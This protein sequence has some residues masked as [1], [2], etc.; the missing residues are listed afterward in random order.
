MAVPDN[1]VEKSIV[2]RSAKSVVRTAL[3]GLGQIILQQRWVAGIFF[4]A[5]ISW[6]S[7]LM[8][9]AA[10][11]GSLIGSGWARWRGYPDAE[12]H[13]GMYGFNAALIALAVA[14]V[15]RT[16][17][18]EIFWVI[19][20]CIICIAL[21]TTVTAIL[22]RRGVPVYTA[23]F[24]IIVWLQLG[25]LMDMGMVPSFAT[26]DIPVAHGIDWPNAILWSFGQIMFL[27]NSI[28]GALVLTGIALASPRAALWGSVAA[29]GSALF[30]VWVDWD[31]GLINQ[32]LFGYN[33]VLVAIALL[34]VPW[35]WRAGGILLSFLIM[36]GMLELGW[37]ALTAPF[38]LSAW[39]ISLAR[40]ATG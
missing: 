6:H 3:L 17:L 20:G 23:P 22:L 8:G 4:L 39:L 33:A 37:V 35:L 30:A 14:Q 27:N 18:M 21:A 10:V 36:H 25:I 28:S 7:P 5:A 9:G 12:V 1:S 40:K 2:S 34:R 11:V 32:G 31:A 19:P 29:I 38:V 13:S 26:T 15:P 24:V 16:S